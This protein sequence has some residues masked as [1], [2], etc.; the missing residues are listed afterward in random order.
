MTIPPSLGGPSL[1]TAAAPLPP[2]AVFPAR[3]S[4]GTWRTSLPSEEPLKIACQV[5]STTCGAGALLGLVRRL[6]DWIITRA[7][8]SHYTQ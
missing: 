5:S 2:A 6:S 1:H 8:V 7:R 3:H 4:P